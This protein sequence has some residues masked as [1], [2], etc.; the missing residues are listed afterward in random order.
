MIQYDPHRWLDHLFDVKGSLIPEITLRVFR[1]WSGPARWSRSIA[2]SGMSISP[3]RFTRW[4]G[5]ARAAPGLPHQ[6][7]VRPVLGRPAI[8]GEPDQR[9]AEPARVVSVHLRSDPALRDSLIRWIGA[10]PYAVKNVLRGPKGW[11]RS[12]MSCPRPRS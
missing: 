10:F 8:V 1:A 2:T 6:F 9:D 12:P 7:V 3:R 5:R 4:W 11:A